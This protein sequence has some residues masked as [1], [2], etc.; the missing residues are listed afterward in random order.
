MWRPRLTLVLLLLAHALAVLAGWAVVTG[1]TAA[2][3][4]RTPAGDSGSLETLGRYGEVPDFALV[5]RT[6]LTR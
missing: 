2:L 1:R 3:L 6:L 5:L 4:G